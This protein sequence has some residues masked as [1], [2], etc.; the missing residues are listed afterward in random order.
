MFNKINHQFDTYR[1]H[2]FTWFLSDNEE[3]YQ[4]NLKTNYDKL[5]LNGWIDRQFTYKFNS[6]GFR[7]EEFTD[8]DSIMFLGCSFTAGVGLPLEDMW[9]YQVA[10]SLN[11]KCVNLG[12]AGT[13]PDTAFRLAN[14]YISQIKPKIVIFLNS[15]PGRFSLFSG[16][17]NL[18]YFFQINEINVFAETKFKT[19]YE[20]WLS[21]EEN[22][23]LDT[24]KHKLAIQS[25]CQENKIRFEYAD[26]R[27]MSRDSL[28][29]DLMHYGTNSNKKFAELIM[30]RINQNN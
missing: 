8:E 24:L 15:P 9:A 21:C 3:R 1:Y 19:F 16:L 6:H 25:L 2:E 27:E 10:K 28:A 7:C 5:N 23:V 26:W 30:D 14:H 11:L 4:E 20:H 13:G 17:D 12:V 29:R 22:L 18:F